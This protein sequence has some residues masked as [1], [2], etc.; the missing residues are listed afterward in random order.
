MS[1]VNETRF[2]AQHELCECKCGL[3]ESVCNSKQ[4]RFECKELDAWSSCKDAY[5]WNPS[6]CDL[7]VIRHLKLVNI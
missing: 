4:C 5:K 1:C 3:N 6:T 2:L 7:S